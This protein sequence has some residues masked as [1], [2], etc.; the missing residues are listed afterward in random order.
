VADIAPWA[1]DQQALDH[2]LIDAGAGLDRSDGGCAPRGGG[3]FICAY[4]GQVS[5]PRLK[6]NAELPVRR[7]ADS[8]V[9]AAAQRQRR[10]F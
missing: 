4:A 1:L 10:L 3:I 7:L 2:R 5:P 9:D 8:S 6:I